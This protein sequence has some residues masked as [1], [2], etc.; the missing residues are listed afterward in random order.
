TQERSP[1][2]SPDGSRVLFTRA[3]QGLF[4]KPVNGA[5]PE[6]PLIQPGERPTDWA[7]DGRTSAYSLGG[8][9]MLFADGKP[10]QFTKTDFVEQFARLSPDGSLIAYSSND[11]RQVWDVW[12]ETGPA[13]S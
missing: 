5:A 1:I 9:I 11:S 3:T 12:V 2:W 4:E 10:A 7:R 8:H 13:G 6:R